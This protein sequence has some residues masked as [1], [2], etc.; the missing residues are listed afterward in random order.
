VRS[1]SR[2]RTRLAASQVV[3]WEKRFLGPGAEI[4]SLG[5]TNQ[6]PVLIGSFQS[7]EFQMQRLKAVSGCNCESSV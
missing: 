4:V 3:N 2:I 1:D 7:A 5:M 6:D